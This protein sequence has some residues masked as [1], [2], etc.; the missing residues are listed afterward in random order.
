M[1]DPTSRDSLGAKA[2]ASFDR[3]MFLASSVTAGAFV[4]GSGASATTSSRS[5][6]VKEQLFFIEGGREPIPCALW[7]AEGA[8]GPRPLV[9][10]GHGGGGSKKSGRIVELAERFAR[11]GYAV[12]AIDQP[13][14]GDRA[15][16]E[17]LPENMAETRR[18]LGL[19]EMTRRTHAATPQ[20]V[21]DWRITLNQLQQCP[22]IGL[23]GPVAYWGVSLG[24]RY[25]VPLV[26]ADKRISV[27]IFGLFGFA[28]TI[29]PDAMKAAA[30]LI[31]VPLQ[32]YHQWNDQFVKLEGVLS[33]Y[34]AFASKE[35]SLHINPGLHT[36]IPQFEYDAMEQFLARH[37][38]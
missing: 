10:M 26:A 1:K 30:T 4:L 17:F 15:S 13:N 23:G 11:R 3:R 32:Y 7:I 34:E 37:L 14:H 24:T 35:K 28:D 29:D 6:S 27:A 5:A 19:A 12:A 33:M 22:E 16:P 36:E 25:G 9:L 21:E 20:S 38:G 18:K 8:K 2:S 31:E